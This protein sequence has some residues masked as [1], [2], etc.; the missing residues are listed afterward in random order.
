MTFRPRPHSPIIEIYEKAKAGDA[1]FVNRAAENGDLAPLPEDIRRQI[2]AV[3]NDEAAAYMQN[4][5]IPIRDDAV[6]NQR[7]FVE[8]HSNFAINVFAKVDGRGLRE[9]I[10]NFYE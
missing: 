6:E 2:V 8:K 4:G 1:F 7:T 10:R 5:V 3:A 9:Q